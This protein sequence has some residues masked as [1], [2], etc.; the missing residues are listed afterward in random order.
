MAKGTPR[1]ST[2]GKNK[3][4]V[5][6]DFH[7]VLVLPTGGTV[8]PRVERLNPP[9][10]E[11]AT[12]FEIRLPQRTI[13]RRFSPSR[14]A[15]TSLISVR[16][17]EKEMDELF[18]LFGSDDDGEGGPVGYGHEGSIDVGGEDRDEGHEQDEDV[19]LDLPAS[20]P[21]KRSRSGAAV[22]PPSGAF[23]AGDD[24]SSGDLRSSGRGGSGAM[25]DDEEEEQEVIEILSDDDDAQP[26]ARRSRQA[27]NRVVDRGGAQDGEPVFGRAARGAAAAASNKLGNCSSSGRDRRGG[28]SRYHSSPT[29][30]AKRAFGAM[31]F[32]SARAQRPASGASAAAAA[33]AAAAPADA[34]VVPPF[35]SVRG[36]GRD[37]GGEGKPSAEEMNASASGSAA[38]AAAAGKDAGGGGSGWL[39]GLVAAAKAATSKINS[40]D[41]DPG[42]KSGQIG[43][44]VSASGDFPINLE[45][46][47]CFNPLAVAALFA[48]GHGSCWECAHDWC[49]RVSVPRKG[50]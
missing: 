10:P 8:L 17:C 47:I 5:G 24:S 16:F 43:S 44:A 34:S 20:R 28:L 19:G 27:E 33:A 30:D 50:V 45:C 38:A 13:W 11:H 25:D 1:N 46:A 40:K 3:K 35:K 18:A 48:C 7:F 42:T 4:W 2:R 49:S 21:V 23:G 36:G 29:P 39:G 41:D 26:L 6:V 37:E 15:C 22:S 9:F 14:R 32:G 12:A 31:D